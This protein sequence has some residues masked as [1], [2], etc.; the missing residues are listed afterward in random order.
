MKVRDDHVGNFLAADARLF[1]G[2]DDRAVA[3]AE[4]AALFLVEFVAAADFNKDW[5]CWP[6]SYPLLRY[7]GGG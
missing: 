3:Q 5:A 1:D 7:S 4:D 6:G 2:A